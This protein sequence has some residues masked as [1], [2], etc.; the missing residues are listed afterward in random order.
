LVD[1]DCRCN[2]LKDKGAEQKEVWKKKKQEIKDDLKAHPNWEHGTPGKSGSVEE[3]K[4]SEEKTSGDEE[5]QYKT[6][7]L[8]GFQ[9]NDDA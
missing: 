8:M 7:F 2:L 3:L 6:Q 1:K 9:K 5:K 4:T